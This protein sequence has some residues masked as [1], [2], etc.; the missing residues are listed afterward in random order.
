MKIYIAGKIT[1]DPNYRQKFKKVAD[2]LERG[3]YAVLALIELREG[4]YD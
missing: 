1:G 3:G 2:D 4:R